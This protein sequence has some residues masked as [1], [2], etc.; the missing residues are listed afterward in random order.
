M[1]YTDLRILVNKFNKLPRTPRAPS[2]LVDN[3]WTFCIRPVPLHPPGD[4]IFIIN[5]G[6]RYTHLEGPMPGTFT[7][8]PLPTK[9]K[10]IA[11]FLVKAFAQGMDPDPRTPKL[12][13][14]SWATEDRELA[15]SIGEALRLFEV[16][17]ECCTIGIATEVEKSVLKEEWP[18][19]LNTLTSMMQRNT[20]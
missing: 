12:A 3:H 6:S 13:P 4:V 19:F 16:R 14:W 15:T 5:P 9:A 10:M 17:G 18:R 11:T 7:T 2:G 20:A 1:E 8:L